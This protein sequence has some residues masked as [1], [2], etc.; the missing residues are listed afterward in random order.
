[1]NILESYEKSI[2]EGKTVRVNNVESYIDWSGKWGYFKK[3][4]CGELTLCVHQKNNKVSVIYDIPLEVVISDGW[5]VEEKWYEGDFK[6]KYPNG[7]LCLV[8]TG[9]KGGAYMACIK[10]YT[11]GCFIDDSGVHY[12]NAIPVSPKNA[13]AI[14]GGS[15][16]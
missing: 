4:C 7:V 15:C 1:M 16:E 2:K 5:E 3:D 13:P 12:E 6:N 14:I 8:R 9:I 11:Y 10:N